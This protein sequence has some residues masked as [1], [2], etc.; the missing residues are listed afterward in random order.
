MQE[1]GHAEAVETVDKSLHYL[2][3]RRELIN[4]ARFR[5]QGYPIGSGSVE[6]ANKLVV[7][8]RMKGAGMRW[9]P[10]HVNAMLA[11]R[12]LACNE[13]WAEGWRA[14]RQ[15]WQNNEMARRA[16]RAVRPS[17]AGEQEGCPKP[18]A[19]PHPESPA[20]SQPKLP[21]LTPTKQPSDAPP[22]P[23]SG[24]PAPPHPWRRPF[25]H[26]RSA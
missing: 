1:M 20:E 8:S 23:R 21:G 13:R 17:S 4:Y 14:I 9:E 12:N 19:L 26:R 7:H 18:S 24:R 25:L 5:A 15:T 10:S 3:E 11:M 2:R 22:D 6:S 16:Q